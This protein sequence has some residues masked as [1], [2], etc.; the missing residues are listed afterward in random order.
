MIAACSSSRVATKEGSPAN[1]IRIIHEQDDAIR[2]L[3]GYGTVAISS[4]E[5]SN[6][7]SIDVSLRAPDSLRV[8]I[9]GPFGITLGTVF[10]TRSHYIAYDA[11]DNTVQRGSLDSNKYLPLPGFTLTF[12][13]AF[14]FLKGLPPVLRN[15]QK[16]KDSDGTIEGE[17]ANGRTIECII[18]KGCIE[19]A[20]IKQPNGNDILEYFSEY[21]DVDGINFPERIAASASSKGKMSIH[22]DDISLNT[23][24]LNFSI[25][26]PKDAK[27]ISAQ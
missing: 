19:K 14:Q 13:D 16:G 12:E 7:A 15:A 25:S 17:D 24:D 8:K 18:G 1:A 4:P 3:R 27:V 20:R 2:S 5:L 10:A 23:Q 26:V 11:W 6:T 22:Y 9:M 21:G